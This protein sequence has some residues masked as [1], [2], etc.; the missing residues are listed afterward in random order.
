[1]IHRPGSCPSVASQ[2]PLFL[3]FIQPWLWHSRS[4]RILPRLW[5]AFHLK[6]SWDHGSF[7]DCQQ[8]RTV[9]LLYKSETASELVLCLLL[10]TNLLNHSAGKATA[11]TQ[12]EATVPFIGQYKLPLGPKSHL[13]IHFLKWL[14]TRVTCA[15]KMHCDF[16]CF[17]Y[18]VEK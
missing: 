2:A 8:R 14:I 10:I 6:P 5:Q 7:H 13:C 17:L 12:G 16:T 18:Y 1:M 4:R 11:R 9:I 3:H 15:P